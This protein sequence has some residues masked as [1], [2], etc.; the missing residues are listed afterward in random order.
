MCSLKFVIAVNFNF[1]NNTHGWIHLISACFVFKCSPRI[2]KVTETADGWNGISADIAFYLIF[3][4]DRSGWGISVGEKISFKMSKNLYFWHHLIL[5][6]L[7]INEHSIFLAFDISWCRRKKMR[8]S[9][10]SPNPIQLNRVEFLEPKTST[11]FFASDFNAHSF[12]C[13]LF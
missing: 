4:G 3:D 10:K 12:Y 2:L 6:E 5:A 1:N 11:L 8:F 9:S 13:K 7:A